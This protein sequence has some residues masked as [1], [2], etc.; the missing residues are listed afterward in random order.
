MAHPLTEADVYHR[1]GGRAAL[2]QLIDPDRVGAW[3]AATLDLAMQDAWNFVTSAVQ[4]QADIVG[5]TVQQLRDQFPDYV[6]L[7]AMKALKLVWTYGSSGQACPERISELD[8]MADAQ[9]QLLAERR[10]KHGG[11][12]TDPAAAQ[13][14]ARVDIDPRNERMTLRSFRGFI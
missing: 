6:S 10:R 8:K 12:N 13:R 3:D 11:Q 7:A 9:L 14:I 4:V 2:A 5:L 1:V